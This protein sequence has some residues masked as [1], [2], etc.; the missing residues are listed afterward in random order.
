MPLPKVSVEMGHKPNQLYCDHCGYFNKHSVE[1][2]VQ[3]DLETTDDKNI[4]VHIN[5]SHSDTKQVDEKFMNEL[6]SRIDGKSDT[7]KDS[8]LGA[9]HPPP[10]A[11][12]PPPPPPGSSIPT[13]PPPPPGPGIPPPPPPPPPP[14]GGPPPPPP[15]PPLGGGPPPPPGGGPPPPPPPPGGPIVP[16]KQGVQC[17]SP[18]PLISTPTPKHKLK[19]FNWTK[20]PPYSVSAGITSY[21]NML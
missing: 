8:L 12:P 3:T 11:P 14:G 16:I 15:P 5:N 2:A 4:K 13:P 20:V 21:F 19:T 9:P 18:V 6:N 10:P 1:C 7:E 17:S